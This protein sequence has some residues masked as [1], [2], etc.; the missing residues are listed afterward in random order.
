MISQFDSLVQELD[1][2]LEKKPYFTLSQLIELGL[3]GSNSAAST[4]LKRGLLPSIKISPKRTVIPRSAV[5]DYF[6]AN[7]VRSNQN[8]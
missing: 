4:A 2:L 1:N 3:F 5:L 7:L 6:K 8:D